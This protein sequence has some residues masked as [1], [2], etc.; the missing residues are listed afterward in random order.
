MKTD[1]GSICWLLHELQEITR[2]TQ[3][4]I[5]SDEKWKNQSGWFVLIH[6]LLWKNLKNNFMNY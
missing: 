4:E 1:H 2:Y 5:D 3:C 6:R